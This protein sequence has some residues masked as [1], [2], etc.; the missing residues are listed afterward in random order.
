[1]F[2]HD[3]RRLIRARQRPPPDIP[4]VRPLRL[5][6]EMTDLLAFRLNPRREP[7]V[8]A[9]LRSLAAHLSVT[10]AP[11]D[12]VRQTSGIQPWLAPYLMISRRE[13]SSSFLQAL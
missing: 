11:A 3:L 4:A 6:P 9:W 13:R 5:R 7:A 2:R 1:M 12:R 8:A 10:G